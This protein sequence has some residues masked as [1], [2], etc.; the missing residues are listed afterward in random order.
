L[1]NSDRM[2]PAFK[3]DTVMF[4]RL[5]RTF[6]HGLR[7]TDANPPLQETEP[8][9]NAYGRQLTASEIAAKEHRP[10]VGG[11]W[12]EVG[13]LQFEFM[14]EQGLLPG[15]RFVDVGCGAM[16][17]G[18]HFVNYLD[19]GNY[20][21]L[22]INPSLMNAAKSELDAL[23]LLHKSPHLLVNDK[24]ELSL[25][26]TKFDFA[27]AVS[28]FTHLF[29]NHITRC[30][31]EVNK[32]LSPN[33]KFYATFFQAPQPAYLDPLLHTPGGITTYYDHD[34]FHCSFSE[35]QNWA[36]IANLQ[37]KLVDDW[38][39]PRDQKMLCFTRLPG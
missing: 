24:F 31:V 33:G 14:K 11:L 20:Y 2:P 26:G 10:F 35:M 16:R 39:H 12:E 21:G 7:P 30:L 13:Q 6:Q 34:P 15:H 8:A 37:V 32:V 36:A 28:V 22:D 17:G 5:R 18:V 1:A 23:G 27:I 19:K 25:F 29:M 4:N 38:S 9:V 3:K